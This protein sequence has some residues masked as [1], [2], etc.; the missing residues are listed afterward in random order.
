ML[1]KVFSKF[2][3]RLLHCGDIRSK[4][5]QEVRQE[6]GSEAKKGRY[7]R[8]NET[9]IMQLENMDYNYKG[10]RLYTSKCKLQVIIKTS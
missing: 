7:K 9:Q 6:V 3:E 4:A 2:G 5:T 10:K 8:Q 1:G